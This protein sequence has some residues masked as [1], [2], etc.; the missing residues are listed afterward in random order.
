[1]NVFDALKLCRTRAE[2]SQKEVAEMA[3]IS[4]SYLSLLERG[5][6]NPNM[7]TIEKICRALNISPLILFFLCADED[8]LEKVDPELSKVVYEAA[9]TAILDRQRSDNLK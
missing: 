6:R 4:V 5:K 9:L 7:S 2:M 3:G 8:G 1:M